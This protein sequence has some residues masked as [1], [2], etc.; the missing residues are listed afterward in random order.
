ME[1]KNG[2]EHDVNIEDNNEEEVVDVTLDDEITDKEEVVEKKDCVIEIRESELNKI[3]EELEASK[4]LAKETQDKVAYIQADFQNYKKILEREKE[5]Y[6]SFAGKDLMLKFLEFVDDFERALPSI[7][8]TESTSSALEAYE[9]LYKQLQD[10]LEKEQVKP[11]EALGKQ[12]D[13][14]LHE[15]MMGEETEKE[16]EGTILEVFKKGYYL[17]DKVLRCS[18]VKIAKQTK[19][20]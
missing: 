2:D 11:I 7:K 4:K 19:K 15:A 16:E 10:I 18:L 9:L 14:Y 1:S 12:F 20:E 5:E 13:P 17:K 3:K 8:N 6:C